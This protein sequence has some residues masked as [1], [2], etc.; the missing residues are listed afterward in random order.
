MAPSSLMVFSLRSLVLPVPMASSKLG[1]RHNAS[2]YFETKGV[3]RE[4]WLAAASQL[5]ANLRLEIHSEIPEIAK[6]RMQAQLYFEHAFVTS[7]R[8]REFFS[9]FLPRGFWEQKVAY[10]LWS[11]INSRP[12]IIRVI[13]KPHLGFSLKPWLRSRC[14]CPWILHPMRSDK[15][16]FHVGSGRPTSSSDAA[17][18]IASGH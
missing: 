12:R 15:I 6:V 2:G 18:R 9:T 16:S 10:L 13:S 5:S 7:D 11:D 1:R 17:S 14:R 3:F 4:A 8:E